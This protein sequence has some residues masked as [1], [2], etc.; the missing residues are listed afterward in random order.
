MGGIHGG[1]ATVAL[2]F[3]FISL[4]LLSGHLFAFLRIIDNRIFRANLDNSYPRMK[5]NLV[6]QTPMSSVGHK[7]TALCCY[8]DCSLLRTYMTLS[9]I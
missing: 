2:F 6:M 5:K 7:A 1:D 9:G 4:L 3:S 8:S